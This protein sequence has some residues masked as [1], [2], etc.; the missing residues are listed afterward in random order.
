MLAA[1]RAVAGVSASLQGRVPGEMPRGRGL[2]CMGACAAV[3]TG[4]WR[5]PQRAC[6]TSSMPCRTNKGTP[7][8]LPRVASA[9]LRGSQK[10]LVSVCVLL[11]PLVGQVTSVNTI[12]T[13]A[14]SGPKTPSLQ[15]KRPSSAPQPPGLDQVKHLVRVLVLSAVLGVRC[16]A[17]P[18]GVVNGGAQAWR[19]A[20]GDK[21]RGKCTSL[22]T[23]A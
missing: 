17:C 6:S 22:P 23:C 20:V 19:A 4:A 5:M 7:R 14:P 2:D 16:A 11:V 21:R 15:R 12:A 13:Q 1:V 8:K 10:Y 9:L 3:A 18:R